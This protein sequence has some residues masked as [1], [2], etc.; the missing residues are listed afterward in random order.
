MF[1]T[2]PWLWRLSFRSPLIRSASF[3][4]EQDS[5]CCSE[6]L[7]D[8]GNLLRFVKENPAVSCSLPPTQ[9]RQNFGSFAF[10]QDEGQPYEPVFAYLGCQ[11]ILMLN[12][13]TTEV[14]HFR[15]RAW[16]QGVAFEG[17]E[18][19]LARAACGELG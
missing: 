13:F 14:A 1:G 7:I 9:F 10:V 6:Q 12:L 2:S 19:A 3:P 18:E 17:R 11:A 15:T 16:G 8:D 5:I 4:G